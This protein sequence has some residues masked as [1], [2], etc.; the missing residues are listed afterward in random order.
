M[1]HF[2]GTTTPDYETSLETT[3]QPQLFVQTP[4][5]PPVYTTPT[6]PPPTAGNK[7]DML[8]AMDSSAL[9]VYLSAHPGRQLFLSKLMM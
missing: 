4:Q 2:I 5:P 9:G 7:I 8:R 1:N 6:A 3:S